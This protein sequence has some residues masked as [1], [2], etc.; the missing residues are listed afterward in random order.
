MERTDIYRNSHKRTLVIRGIKFTQEIE[1]SKSMF[2]HD[3]GAVV[4]IKTITTHSNAVHNDPWV[5]LPHLR[6]RFLSY[7]TY[8]EDTYI[9][10]GFYDAT[11]LPPF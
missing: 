3:N 10:A 5:H 4:F 2:V 9:P 1:T 11:A 8:T 6:F 7:R